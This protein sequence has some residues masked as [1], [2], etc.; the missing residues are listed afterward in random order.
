[1]VDISVVN[2]S[3]VN[4]NLF[5]AFDAL[6]SERNVTRAAKRLGLTQSAVS[7]ALRQL[8][9][10]LG[11]PLFVRRSA[12][13]EPTPR[14]LALAEPVRRGLAAFGAA[15][16]PAVFEPAAAER[17]FVV[18][19]S[20]YVEMV[21]LPPLLKRLAKE[22]PRV[23]LDIVAWGLHEVPPSLARGEV[24]LMIGYYGRLPP[25]HREQ[26]LFRE[27]YVG[28]VRRGHPTIGPR[29][30]LRAWTSVPHVLVS[31]RPGS[32]TGVD[33]ALAARGL[34]REVGVRVSHFL[35]VP[36]IVARTD[37]V[38]SL[39]RR[40]AEPQARALGLVTFRPPIRLPESTVGQVWHD[41]LEADPGHGWLRGVVADVCKGV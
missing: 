7:N 38:A 28:L 11:D 5:V 17:T 12:G 6:L 32:T 21:L 34:S 20:D 24:D 27:A 18:A 36:S 26:P 16:A 1:M 14:A 9:V 13:V 35:L 31:Q 30:S 33:K 19:A 37:F 15:L 2:I 40:I 4:L 3:A 8:R 39:S 10:V 41:R 22:A 23:R 25:A 29:P